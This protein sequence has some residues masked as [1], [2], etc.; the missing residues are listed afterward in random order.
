MPD[1]FV[2]L[3]V[4]MSEASIV[5]AAEDLQCDVATVKAVIDVESR[6]G[7]LEDKRP[8]ILFERHYFS[9]LTEGKHDGT[10]QDI[11]SPK[12]GGYKG[13]VREYDRLR[14]AFR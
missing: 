8:K 14:R 11:C 6:G 9:R 3:A 13:G 12:P 4:R 10:D 7:F 2:G 5:K 1:E